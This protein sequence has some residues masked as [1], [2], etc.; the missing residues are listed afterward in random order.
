L[1][2]RRIFSRIKELL[3]LNGRERAELEHMRK[4]MDPELR[5]MRFENGRFD[6]QIVGPMVERMALVLAGYCQEHKVENYIEITLHT[7][8][9]PFE[10]F[11]VTIQKWAGKTPHQLRREAEIARDAALIHVKQL[12]SE[13][14]ELRAGGKNV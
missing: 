11:G 13:L 7:T 12:E 2:V 6:L 10:S 1:S 9:E 5:M 8:V 14:Q 3:P 4:L